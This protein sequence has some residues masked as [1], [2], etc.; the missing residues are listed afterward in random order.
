MSSSGV[1]GDKTESHASK[2]RI[3]FVVYCKR[4]FILLIHDTRWFKYIGTTHTHY[5]KK[6]I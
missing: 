1:S 6:T 4:A 5:E 2:G 3:P